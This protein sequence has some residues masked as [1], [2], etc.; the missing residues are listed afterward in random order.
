MS[1]REGRA[2]CSREGWQ[3]C[4]DRGVNQH[5]QLGKLAVKHRTV[6]QMW[7][8]HTRCGPCLLH[9]HLNTYSYMA[10]RFLLRN[11]LLERKNYRAKRGLR[12]FFSQEAEKERRK[13]LGYSRFLSPLHLDPALIR[14]TASAAAVV[15]MSPSSS[16]SSSTDST[17]MPGNDQNKSPLPGVPMGVH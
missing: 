4:G 6:L 3:L 9:A 16:S 17:A 7:G 12:H 10:L 2:G 1:N 8:A 13:S 15:S 5:R 14:G 11:N